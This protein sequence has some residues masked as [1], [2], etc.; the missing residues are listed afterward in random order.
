MLTFPDLHP[1]RRSLTP[2]HTIVNMKLVSALAALLALFSTNVTAAL[3]PEP[4][5]ELDGIQDKP[6]CCK[7]HAWLPWS[8]RFFDKE[9]CAEYE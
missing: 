7:H 4:E 5:P 9:K 6:F 8:C 1:D 2:N 3:A